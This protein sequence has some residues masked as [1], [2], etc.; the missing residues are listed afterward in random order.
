MPSIGQ[1]M[2]SDQYESSLAKSLLKP[3]CGIVPSLDV[4][5]MEA[6]MKKTSN[7]IATQ[8]SKPGL[9]ALNIQER[10]RSH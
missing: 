5:L 8:K 2:S 7:D 3:Y 1:F 9:R 4:L 10:S 6:V